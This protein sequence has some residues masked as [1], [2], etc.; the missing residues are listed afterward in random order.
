MPF[1]SAPA[2][3]PR[4]ALHWLAATRQSAAAIGLS[5]FVL[6]TLWVAVAYELRRDER[7]TVERTERSLA[8]LTRA[9]S[10]HTAKTLEGADMALRYTRAEALAQGPA[11]DIGAFQARNIVGPEY[12]LL[13]VA[14]PD[15]RVVHSTQPF[16]QVDLSDRDHFRVHRQSSEDRLFVSKPV[17]GRVSGKWSIQLTRRIEGPG[18]HFDG[19]VV[20]SLSPDYLARFYGS[21]DLGGQGAIALVGTDGV[22][23]ASAGPDG[24]ADFRDVSSSPLF[25]DALARGSGT[26]RAVSPI[27]GVDRLWAFRRL[28]PYGLIVMAGT[29]AE[30]ALAGVQALRGNMLLAAALVTAIVLGFLVLLV[31]RTREQLGLMAALDAGREAAQA[32]SR[33]KTRFLAS[34]SHELRTPLNGILGFA[35]TLRDTGGDPEAR[36]FGGAIHRSAAQLHRL[37]DTILDLVKIET[38]RMTVVPGAVRV[39]ELLRSVHGAQ[40]AEAQARGLRLWL[41]L[42]P[43]CPAML[44]TDARHLRQ[45][46]ERLVDNAVKFTGEGEVSILARGDAAGALVIEVG[47]TGP[48]IPPGKLATIFEPFDSAMG[49]FQHALQGAGLGLPL[50]Q[51]LARLLGGTLTLRSQPGQG[52]TATLCL[53]AAAPA[54]R[55]LPPKEELLH[56]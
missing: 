18:G 2:P 32:A 52:T 15:G 20:L 10:E 23:R 19:V 50:A 45:V 41:A 34:V 53:P 46:L 56:E 8:N 27:D 29:G 13:S 9:F 38:G 37:V 49:S 24:P 33:I 55:S 43:G 17:L 4:P 11:F 16:Q 3:R 35:E 6:A 30:D 54:A 22:V 40:A 26:L 5:G 42:Q 21:V 25:R 47:D 39:E 44:Q 51:A 12:H 31:R 14:G 48:G 36:E 1:P 28:D 7:E